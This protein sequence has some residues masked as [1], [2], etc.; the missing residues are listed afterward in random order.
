MDDDACMHVCMHRVACVMYNDMIMKYVYVHD[1]ACMY[2]CV[3]S[4]HEIAKCIPVC[5][6]RG[7]ARVGGSS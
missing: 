1:D 4:M 5:E 7:S 2:V 3:M 6:E